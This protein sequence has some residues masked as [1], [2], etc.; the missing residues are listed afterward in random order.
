MNI[1]ETLTLED[2]ENL[3][4]NQDLLNLLKEKNNSYWSSC[5]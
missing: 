1:R 4:N 2:F 5:F 3:E